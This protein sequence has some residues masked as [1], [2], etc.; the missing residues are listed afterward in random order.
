MIMSS[1]LMLLE[2]V[3]VLMSVRVMERG[4]RRISG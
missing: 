1:Q 2:G 3:N 4:G